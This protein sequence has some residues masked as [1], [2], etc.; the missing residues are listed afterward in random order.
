M[1]IKLLIIAVAIVAAILIFAATRPA[2]IRVERSVRISAP[3]EKI[4]PLINDFHYWDGWAPQ[5]REDSTM[6][7]SYRGPEKGMGAVSDWVSKGSA[8]RGSMSVTESVAP[9]KVMVRADWTKPF[10][11]TNVNEFTLEPAGDTTK[12][13]WTF[14]GANVFPMKLMGVFANMDNVMGKHLET[15]LLSLKEAAE[16]RD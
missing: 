9:T 2:S 13:V 16:R 4:F 6:K 14:Q 12:V 1:V 8:G 11:L 10:Q 7:R 3:P 15:G 5:D